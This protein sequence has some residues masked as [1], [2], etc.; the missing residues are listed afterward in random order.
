MQSTVEMDTAAL[1]NLL[2]QKNREGFSLLYDRYAPALFGVI[3]KMVKDEQ[4]GE[5]LLQETFIKVWRNIAQF[6]A[7]K[8]TLFTWLLNISRYTVIDYLRS[9]AHRQRRLSFFTDVYETNI[10]E[11]YTEINTDVLGLRSMIS[12]MEPKYRE[13]IDLLYF[14]GY[15]QEEVSRL[16]RIP[17]GTVKSRARFALVHLRNSFKET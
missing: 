2:R 17:L 7:E 12:K 14:W 6:N 15:T 16:L 11:H 13:V 3:C 8:G 4:I 1:V 10:R 9:K 5:D